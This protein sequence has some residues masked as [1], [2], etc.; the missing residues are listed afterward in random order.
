[1]GLLRNL[2]EVQLKKSREKYEVIV[3]NNITNSYLD[4]NTPELS[5]LLG[6][7]WGDGCIYNAKH[8]G[9]NKFIY[10]G[11]NAEDFSDIS[12]LFNDWFV[13][14]RTRK[15][16]SKKITEARN[17][18]INFA[19]FLFKNDFSEKSFKS[20]TKIL[21]Y[22][23]NELKHYFWRGY[24]DADGCFYISKN[25]KTFQYAMAGSYEQDWSDF[26][27]LLKSFNIK[28]TIKRS[29]LKNSKYSVVRFCKKSDFIKFGEYI[30]QGNW[31]GFARKLNKVI[32]ATSN[33]RQYQGI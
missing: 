31:L 28:Y 27:E 5:Y 4:V 30:Y 14:S 11:I 9:R 21:K 1:M 24:S 16:R 2:S 10:L 22:I 3:Q 33:I 12:H 15:N 18:N 32:E 29:H 6:L 19:S 17:H 20:P 25:K 13:S 23:P 8:K 7:I 26:E